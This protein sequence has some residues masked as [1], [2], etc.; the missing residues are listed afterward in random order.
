MVAVIFVVSTITLA[1]VTVASSTYWIT[2]PSTGAIEASSSSDK[3]LRLH[4]VGNKIFDQY[5]RTVHLTGYWAN[6]K[7]YV[8]SSSWGVTSQASLDESQR[9]GVHF[10]RV[11][12]EM[13]RFTTAP[14]TYDDTFFSQ[15][16]GLDWL[17][18]E[19]NK[20]G[21]HVLLNFNSERFGD[22]FTAIEGTGFPAWWIPDETYPDSY[23]GYTMA[24]DDFWMERGP[25][26]ADNKAQ[27]IDA[28]KYV[29]NRYKD[30][31]CIVAWDI[32]C[33]EPV[34]WDISFDDGKAKYYHFIRSLIDTIRSVDPLDRLVSVETLT[35]CQMDPRWDFAKL[36][37]VGRDNVAYQWHIYYPAS[38]VYGRSYDPTAPYQPIAPPPDVWNKEMLDEYIRTVTEYVYTNFNRPLIIGEAGTYLSDPNHLAW[39]QD[40]YEILEKYGV[41]VS[42][43][44]YGDI[45]TGN[46]A[47]WMGD[48]LLKDWGTVLTDVA[49]QDTTPA[50]P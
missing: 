18:S 48:E 6:L 2:L 49:S 32:P 46:T 4:Q 33:N 25:F 15:P 17:I 40:L 5:N 20:R 44:F 9:I 10:I 42:A 7:S 27:V 50:P 22:Y 47:L 14:Y 34:I 35:M 38:R 11:R 8:W 12:I 30:E 43:G 19:C 45:G 13:G 3:F 1:S 21:I 36:A 41:L 37:D 23:D 24:W 28:W 29:V 26:T 16:H 39:F 31:P